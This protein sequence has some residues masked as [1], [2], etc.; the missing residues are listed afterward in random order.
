MKINKKCLALATV[1]SVVVKLITIP[2]LGL[3]LKTDPVGILGDFFAT[4]LITYGLLILL[5]RVVNSRRRVK[6]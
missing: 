3:S 4:L 2:N 5:I 1:Y 6:E